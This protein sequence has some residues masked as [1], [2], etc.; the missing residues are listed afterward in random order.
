MSEQ[1]KARAQGILDAL[2]ELGYLRIDYDC[3]HRVTVSISAG[4]TQLSRKKA[5]ALAMIKLR[6]KIYQAI[7]TSEEPPMK[8]WSEKLSEINRKIAIMNLDYNPDCDSFDE[9]VWGREMDRL[10]DERKK[11]LEESENQ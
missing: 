8:S 1:Q 10:I 5:T 9:R 11:L 7:M 6:G 3:G 4:D 2:K